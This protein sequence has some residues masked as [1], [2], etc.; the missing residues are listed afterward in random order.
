MVGRSGDPCASCTEAFLARIIRLGYP[1][2]LINYVCKSSEQAL[3]LS[4]FIQGRPMTKLALNLEDLAVDSFAT[5]SRSDARGTVLGQAA[6]SSF[7][8][9]CLPQFTDG[10]SCGAL[11]PCC[12]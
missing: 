11:T 5:N 9:T 3:E 2:F 4:A 1:S 6:G 7:E 10:R 12:A 8:R